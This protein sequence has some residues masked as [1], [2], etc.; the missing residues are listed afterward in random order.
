MK[1]V[2]IRLVHLC[3]A[4]QARMVLFCM[5]DCLSAPVRHRGA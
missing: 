1:A 4:D 2:Q 5:F 3:T